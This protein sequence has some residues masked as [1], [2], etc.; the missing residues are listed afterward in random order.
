MAGS[1]QRISRRSLLISGIAATRLLAVGSKG[2]A[3]PSE[4]RRYPDPT[5]E[6]EVFR[7]TDPEHSSTLPA[8]YNRAIARSS[9]FLLYSSDRG[10]SPQAFRMDLKRVL[11][12]SEEPLYLMPVGKR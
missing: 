8:Y 9:G 12:I 4:W 1:T 7:L 3:F 11:G 5:T 2:N 6:L 10:G